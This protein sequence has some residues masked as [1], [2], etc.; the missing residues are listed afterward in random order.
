MKIRK[1]IRAAAAVLLISLILSSCT[2]FLNTLTY[3][4]DK[5]LFTDKKTGIAYTNAPSAYEPVEAGEEYAVWKS[6]GE[7]VIFSEI[8]GMNPADWLMEEGKTVFYAERVSLPTLS[9]MKPHFLYICIEQAYTVVI[10]T[11]EDAE[12]IAELTER[13]ESGEPVVY[14]ATTPDLSYR[15]KFLSEDYPGLYYSLIYAKYSDG[16]AYLYSR[17]SGRCVEAGEIIDLAVVTG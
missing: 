7:K 13:W 15:I 10:S 2:L 17:D 3:D 4:K 9:E 6:A 16:S 1:T 8:K 14:P 12:D 11:I 5:N